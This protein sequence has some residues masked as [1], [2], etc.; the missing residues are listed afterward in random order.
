M[1]IIF[2][3]V[4]EGDQICG[5]IP[6]GEI[7]QRFVYLVVGL[8]IEVIGLED[9]HH[10]IDGIIFNEDPSQY[11]LLRL[12]ILRRKFVGGEVRLVHETLLLN[13]P[14][15]KMGGYLWMEFDGYG[16]HPHIFNGFL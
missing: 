2:Q 4:R 16:K 3:F 1:A 8:P 9:L 13:H 15:F 7:D 5:F 14:N 10:L 11:R 12:D 6:L